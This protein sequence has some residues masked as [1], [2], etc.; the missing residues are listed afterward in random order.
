MRIF[1]TSSHKDLHKTLVKIFIYHRDLQERR[2]KCL[3]DRDR[4][5]HEPDKR[6]ARA[7]TIEMHMDISQEQFYARICRKMPRP[8]T[9]TT[10]LRE[11]APRQSTCTWTY[12]NSH[13]MREFTEICRTPRSGLPSR[14]AV[15]HLRRATHANIFQGKC[16]GADGAP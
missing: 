3:Q 16:R 11:P 12:Q 5:G 7:C 2:V 8:R 14:N 13:F 1:T 10:V 6:F 9:G 15:G 4:R